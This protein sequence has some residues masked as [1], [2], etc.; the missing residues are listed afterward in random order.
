MGLRG[1]G[2]PAGVLARG[3]V[4]PWPVNA[5]PASNAALSL[6]GWPRRSGPGGTMAVS[7]EDAVDLPLRAIAGRPADGKWSI[8]RAQDV[9]DGAGH[10]AG[11]AWALP[12]LAGPVRCTTHEE[13]ALDRLRTV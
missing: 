8:R 11:P 9:V 4:A 10:P 2:D 13:K 7:H 12:A 6:G 1:R 3:R 5:C